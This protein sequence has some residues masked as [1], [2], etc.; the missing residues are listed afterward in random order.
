M[1]NIFQSFWSLLGS[2]LVPYSLACINLAL[3]DSLYI[4]HFGPIYNTLL[5]ILAFPFLPFLLILCQAYAELQLKHCKQEDIP[6]WTERYKKVKEG[7]SSF[8]RTELGCETTIQSFIGL[9]L[10]AFS[11]S[12]T[13][14]SPTLSIFDDTKRGTISELLGL[15]PKTLLIIA[16]VWSLV[17][18]WRSFIRGLKASKDRFPLVSQ[19][20]L[21]FY[22]AFSMVG[23][24][25]ACL[26][27]LTPCLGLFD[28][29]RHY[30]GLLKPYSIVRLSSEDPDEY[31]HLN[32]STD[33]GVYANHTFPWAKLTLH[34]YTKTPP[35]A[36]NITVFTVIE[37]KVMLIEFWVIFCIQI[38]LIIGVK[39]LANPEI[40]KQ[41]NYVKVLSH[42]IENIWIPAPMQD[43]DHVHAPI[44][45][46]KRKRKRI[47]VEMGMTIGLNLLVNLFMLFPMWILAIKVNERHEFLLQTIEPL[48]EEIEAHWRINFVAFNMLW[49]FIVGAVLQ[50][51]SYLVYNRW[52]HPYQPLISDEGMKSVVF[53]FTLVCR[54]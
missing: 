3:G 2:L 5:I 4:F 52:C 15:S 46:Y 44:D 40:F 33:I 14:I 12:S 32:V 51:I 49:I 6:K 27:F 48:P 29:L 34:D 19:A 21:L 43:W 31:G 9:L 47:D 42:A 1:Y 36:P 18:G 35:Q 28:C 45:L 30:Q 39:S 38:I 37:E 20:I 50:F 10:L 54:T 25:A 22:T 41:L 26:L 8:I 7:T 17:S 24:I 53:I 11:V 16:N 23:K 13:R